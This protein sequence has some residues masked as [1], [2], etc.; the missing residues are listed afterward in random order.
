MESL[1]TKEFNGN[2]IHTFMWNNKPCWI[3]NQIVS[4]FGYADASK[5]ILQCIEKEE[6]ETDVEYEMLKGED[7]KKFR[8]MVNL[9]T[10]SEVV[11]K[12]L[13]SN[14]ARHL[15]IFYEDGLYGFMQYTDKPIG[16][17]FRKWLRRDVLPE[18]RQTGVYVTHDIKGKIIKM[19][20]N[21]ELTL[22]DFKEKNVNFKYMLLIWKHLYKIAGLELPLLEDLTLDKELY[23]AQQIAKRLGIY[24]KGNK[25][26]SQ[27]IKAILAKIGIKEDEKEIVPFI[28]NGHID[29]TTKY[30]ET[31]MH[32]I[33]KWIKENNYPD[34]IQGEKNN[35]NVMYTKKENIDDNKEK[36]D[37]NGQLSFIK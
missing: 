1:L 24:S 15:I 28:I 29:T 34:V 31:T 37:T 6:F 18:I 30:T 27:A 25:P 8:E 26:H 14:K 10:T 36:E 9:A 13:I 22:P 11:T 23:E 12:D 17:K 16:V 35:L 33:E 21:I 19:N 4:S 7:L 32:K 3:A 20:N 2:E 5:T